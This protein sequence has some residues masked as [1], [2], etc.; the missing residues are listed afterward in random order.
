MNRRAALVATLACA[1][2]L[3]TQSAAARPHHLTCPAG[4]APDW[5]QLPGGG[6]S[7]F[8]PV[9]A[10]LPPGAATLSCVAGE[11]GGLYECDV[12]DEKPSGQ[13]LGLWALHVSHDFRLKRPGCPPNAARFDLLLRFERSG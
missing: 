9:S 13:G 1:V 3:S 2:S 10:G 12:V 8:Y 4:K 6:G 7:D 11:D 5:A